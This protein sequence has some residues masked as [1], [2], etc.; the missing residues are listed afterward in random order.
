LWKDGATSNSFQ[1][2]LTDLD[3]IESVIA[4][5]GHISTTDWPNRYGPINDDPDTD[6]LAPC[7]PHR[8]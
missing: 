1:T 6:H 5:M 3:E 4:T 7:C 8:T 2:E